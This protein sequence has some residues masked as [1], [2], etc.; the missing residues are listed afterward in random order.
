MTGAGSASSSRRSVPRRL[1]D[2]VGVAALVYLGVC[3]ALLVWALVV[4][5]GETTDASMAGVIPFLATAPAS[6]AFLMLPA[7]G[8]GY[9]TAIAVGAA[10]NAAII[11]WCT[12]ALRRGGR[13][14]R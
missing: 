11:G 2:H 14:D 4:D 10:V 3:A 6:L 13:P 7:N 9:F 1:L 8:F 5:A 12:R